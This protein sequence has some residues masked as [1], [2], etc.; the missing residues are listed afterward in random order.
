M[1]VVGWQPA[2]NRVESTRNRGLGKLQIAANSS[3]K[4]GLTGQYRWYFCGFR[5]QAVDYRGPELCGR[6]TRFSSSL[7]NR[8]LVRTSSCAV[9]RP[10]Y[11]R[12]KRGE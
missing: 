8:T 7:R 11:R 1:V 5:W 9:K 10:L 2:L 6:R 4:R 12:K 3:E